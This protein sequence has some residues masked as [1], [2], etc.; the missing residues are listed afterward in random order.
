MGAGA[1]SRIA[2]E[3]LGTGSSAR[4]GVGPAFSCSLSCAP[5]DENGDTPGAI[6]PSLRSTPQDSSGRF[7]HTAL[8]HCRL[9]ARPRRRPMTHRAAPAPCDRPGAASHAIKGDPD[10][11]TRR[12]R[13]P[14]AN[15]PQPT[16]QCGGVHVER[17]RDSPTAACA[18]G[19]RSVGRIA[20]SR[21]RGKNARQ[22]PA[23][24]RRIMS[25]ATPRTRSMG[26]A[27][28]CDRGSRH[29]ARRRRHEHE[30]ACQHER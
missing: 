18:H 2:A 24:S 28:A 21:A 6:Q 13:R 19:A 30:P 12:L 15:S 29:S 4:D 23:E 17:L 26:S 10:R 8:G 5:V 20:A 22:A 14:E 11:R 25:V 3:E 9:H 7:P 1:P 27:R 16:P